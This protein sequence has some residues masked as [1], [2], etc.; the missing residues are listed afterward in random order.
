MNLIKIVGTGF[1]GG[2]FGGFCGSV[3]GSKIYNGPH[4]YG[5]VFCTGT[6]LII[7]SVIGG[8]HGSD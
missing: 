6:G 1:L 3:I 8:V 2:F 4:K 5:I 7:G